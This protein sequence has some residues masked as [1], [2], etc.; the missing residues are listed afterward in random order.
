[1]P[2]FAGKLSDAEKIAVIAYIQNWCPDK[3]YSAWI[4]RG[5]LSK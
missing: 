1:M 2:A 3:I 4:E 5:G